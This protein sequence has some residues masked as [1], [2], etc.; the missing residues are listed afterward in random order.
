MSVVRRVLYGAGCALGLLGALPLQAAPVK[1]LGLAEM[2]CAAWTAARGDAETRAQQV[3]WVRGFLSGHNYARQAQQV[4]E[5]SPGTV[6]LFV[7]RFCNERPKASFVDAAQ[8]MSDQYSGR[9]AP[10]TR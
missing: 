4:S 6:E 3:A 2:S 9:N 7:T 1:T 5:V 10:I 8:R